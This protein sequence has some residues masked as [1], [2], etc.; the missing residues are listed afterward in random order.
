MY[1]FWCAR[2]NKILLDV[3]FKAVNLLLWCIFSKTGISHRWNM[4][5]LP[6]LRFLRIPKLIRPDMFLRPLT[7]YSVAYF[8]KQTFRLD[9]TTIFGVCDNSQNIQPDMFW[10]LCWSQQRFEF[11]Q[12]PLRI[13]IV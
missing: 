4:M 11:F 2:A 10:F 1:D 7:P 8:Q 13:W 6:F 12:E 9:E 3:I 5:K